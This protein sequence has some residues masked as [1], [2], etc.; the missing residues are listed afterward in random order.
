MSALQT[1]SS[2]K[3]IIRHKFLIEYL[4]LILY[5]TLCSAHRILIRTVF[6]SHS[7]VTEVALVKA[8]IDRV[9][10]AEGWE[11]C[12]GKEVQESIL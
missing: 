9:Q 4:S 12:S 8:R 3:Q 2:H 5:I 6:L 7:V 1:H 11:K 10:E